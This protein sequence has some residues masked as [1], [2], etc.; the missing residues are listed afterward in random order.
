MKIGNQNEP[1]SGGAR[2]VIVGTIEIAPGR[3]NQFLPLLMAHKAR[4][5]KDEPGTLQ[6]EILTSHEDK[7]KVHLYEVY[8]DA[9]AFDTH[10]NG[11]S[12]AQFREESAG[13]IGKIDLAKCAVV[14]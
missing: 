10:R 7:T 2:L 12:M 11:P 14:G 4:C 9:A 8:E 1:T 3:R 5:L 13:M 6:F